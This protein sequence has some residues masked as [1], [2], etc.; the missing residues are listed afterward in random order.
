MKVSDYVENRNPH[1]V[2][3]PEIKAYGD[4]QR[5]LYADWQGMAHNPG[6]LDGTTRRALPG[7]E[8]G[9]RNQFY[10]PHILDKGAV[11]HLINTYG[12]APMGKLVGRAMMRANP[13]LTEDVAEKLGTKYVRGI[14]KLS[15]GSSAP[16]TRPV[17]ADNAEELKRFLREESGLSDD[18]IDTI[19]SV[20]NP[21]KARNGAA[22]RG[23]KR[24]LF[25]MDM[26]MEMRSQHGEV[27][28]VSIAM[29]S[30]TFTRT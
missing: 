13:E 24:A 18:E 19:F 17:S 4:A 8:K 1:H 2:Y 20:V 5:A 11:R 22:P 21:T 12:T 26:K 27:K 30:G 29:M 3:E 9:E 25:D 6:V 14:D 28:E 10:L 7:F 23:K 15:A 16:G